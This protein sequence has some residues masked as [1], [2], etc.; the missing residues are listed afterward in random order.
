MAVN[1]TNGPTKTNGHS[2]SN[3][4]SAYHAA[5]TQEAIEAEEQFAA[6]N[7]HP[8]PVVFARA[9]GTSVWDPEGRH[10]LDFLSAYSAV[11]QG[12]CHP[13]LVAALV[14]Q[15]S[16]VTL[17]SRAFY[18]DVFPRFAQFVTKYFGFDMV[19]PM[20]T[21]AEAVETGIK[22]A[23][24]WGYKV[25]GIPE[26]QALVL[27]AENNFH[28]RT[29]AA[30]SLSSDPE[31][32][33]NYGPYLPGIGCNIPGTDKPIT[34][35]DK[36][37]LR[38]AFEKAGP[39]LAAFLVEPI[40]GEAGIVVPDEDYLQEAR[41]LCDKYNA[42]LI[43]DEI[44][45]GIARTGKLL[46]HEW[47]G[48]KPDLVLLGKAI[49]GGM[50]PVSCVLGRKDVML[51]IEPGTH[52]STYGGNPL[53]CAV[54]IRALEVVQEEQMVERAEKLGHVFR[55][56]LKAIKSPII[57]TVRGKGLLNAIVIDESKTNGH[58]AWD[59]CMLMKEKGLLAKPTHENIIR[60]A[61]PLVITDDEIKKSLEIIAE[62][63]SELPTIKS[64]AEGQ[65]VPP[66]EK[67]A[68]IGVE[69]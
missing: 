68:K 8:L 32:R 18:N 33:D 16:R 4:S 20:N 46:C 14:D 48:I 40:Q 7:Y 65:A 37:A 64:A 3:G 67:K 69:N 53:G 12:H 45:T 28:G 34:Y 30:I 22:I 66:P 35:N 13:K 38:E 6:H 58:S 61:P 17:S 54:A 41:A 2:V 49:S 9:Q 5:S 23:R 36:A 15:A 31:S 29:F 1:G 21:G 27:S 25:K 62:A 57:Q 50:Y 55:D 47:S 39:N 42:L 19:L 11:N 24:K 51:T 44:Q 60:L 59:L 26:N 52:G 43:C 10:Y 63:V 56:G